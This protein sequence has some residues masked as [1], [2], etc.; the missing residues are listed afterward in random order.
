M[1]YGPSSCGDAIVLTKE[2]NMQWEP[3]YVVI[4]INKGDGKIDFSASTGALFHNANLDDK[5]SI[6]RILKNMAA[7]QLERFEKIKEE[8]G[9][10]IIDTA[11]GQQ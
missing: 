9:A 7:S 8:E 3:V 4:G 1:A 2:S 11:G 10:K 6:L 5:I